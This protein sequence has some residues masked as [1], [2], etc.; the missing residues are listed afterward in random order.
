MASPPLPSCVMDP[1]TRGGEHEIDGVDVYN[2]SRIIERDEWEESWPPLAYRAMDL[3]TK[4]ASTGFKVPLS[5]I[6]LGTSG[7]MSGRIHGLPTPL[8]RFLTSML[9][10]VS[11]ASSPSKNRA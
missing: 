5:I 1:T 8:L 6:P 10:S 2:A 4:E 3:V 9:P 11:P 7:E